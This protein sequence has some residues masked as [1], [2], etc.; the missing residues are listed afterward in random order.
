MKIFPLTY[1][2]SDEPEE[3]KPAAT[4]APTPK[5]GRVDDGGTEEKP[6]KKRRVRGSQ[7]W[8]KLKL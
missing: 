7:L 4:G 6:K 5:R 3:E 2:N 8:K 1:G